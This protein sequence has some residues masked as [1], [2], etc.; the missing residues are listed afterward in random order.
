MSADEK[1]KSVSVQLAPDVLQLV[2]DSAHHCTRKQSQQINYLL[3]IAMGLRDGQ[4]DPEFVSWC[5]KRRPTIQER[6][7]KLAAWEEEILLTL[8]V[9]VNRKREQL[10]LCPLLTDSEDELRRRECSVEGALKGLVPFLKK[11]FAYIADRFA[12]NPPDLQD[13]KPRLSVIEG[14]KD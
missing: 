10:A 6:L 1:P 7:H 8:E 3:E 11:E 9:F 5:N 4:D 14:G 2:K 12:E 13:F